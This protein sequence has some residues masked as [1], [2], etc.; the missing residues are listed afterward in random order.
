ERRL[1]AL[2]GP[3]H[4]EPLERVRHRLGLPATERR[5]RA[6]APRSAR[7]LG[8]LGDRVAQPL[9]EL[10]FTPGRVRLRCEARIPEDALELAQLS[11]ML[12][13]ETLRLLLE[14][15]KVLRSLRQRTRTG[16]LGPAALDARGSVRRSLTT[17]PEA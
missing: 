1:T 5:L 6:S 2:D 13:A 11:R 15:A 10:F 12:F 3:L 4:I 8:Q 16:A 14:G 9:S 7:P 17:S